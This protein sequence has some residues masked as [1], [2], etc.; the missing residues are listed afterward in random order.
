ME[1]F[2]LFILILN[3]IYIYISQ[4]WFHRNRFFNLV[5]FF[6]N[7]CFCYFY[8]HLLIVLWMPSKR[9]LVEELGGAECVCSFV[10]CWVVL[11]QDLNLKLPVATIVSQ[12]SVSKMHKITIKLFYMEFL[13]LKKEKTVEL[14]M[15][16]CGSVWVGCL[17]VEFVGYVVL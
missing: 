13:F 10:G 16:Y 8:H 4:K 12:A 6:C 7:Y 5:F 14:I 17:G 3:V 9:K 11:L 2:T 15:V 1:F